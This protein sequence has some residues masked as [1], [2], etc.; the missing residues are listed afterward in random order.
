MNKYF[1]I[2]LV[3]LW[4]CDK[5]NHS[6][7]SYADEASTEVGYANQEKSKDYK[8][9]EEVV[10]GNEIIK[11]LKLI[12]RGSIAYETIDLV[13]TSTQ[14]N[15]AISK[16]GGYSSSES[17]DATDYR[18][19]RNIS[20]RVPY[21][22]FDALLASISEGVEAF[23][24]RE[25]TVDDVTE[26]FF[27][28]SARLKTKKEIEKRL[29]SLLSRANKIPEIIEVEREIGKV[30]SDIERMEG[31]LNYMKNQISL[32]T[33]DIAYYKV[34]EAKSVNNNGFWT[35]LRRAFVNGWDAVLMLLVGLTTLWPLFLLL[36]LGFFGYKKMKR[37]LKK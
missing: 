19:S 9:D 6:E 29:L 22:N 31:R 12:K 24:R 35:K 17:E 5:A 8:P 15:A 16:Y 11:N 1:L 25:I 34:L 14:I 7:M 13:K 37:R 23:D 2:L 3:A 18:I 33:L 4:G 27:D 36:T 20:I 30:R 10:S 28:L 21:K 26:E 32:S